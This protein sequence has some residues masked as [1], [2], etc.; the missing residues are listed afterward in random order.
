MSRPSK[1]RVREVIQEV[2]AL[3]LPDGAHWALI[4][5]KLGLSYGEVFDYIVEDPAFSAPSRARLLIASK[6]RSWRALGLS[7]SRASADIA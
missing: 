6:G 4:H 7:A 2:D 1:E 5:E 3:D